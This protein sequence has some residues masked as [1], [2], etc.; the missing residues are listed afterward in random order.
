MQNDAKRKQA[1]EDQRILVRPYARH[2]YNNEN[3]E[4][5]MGNSFQIK[6]FQAVLTMSYVQVILTIPSHEILKLY[7]LQQSFKNKN[8]HKQQ[9]R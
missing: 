4:H 1:T 7:L 3:P 5:L 6:D 2:H 9:Q 8:K